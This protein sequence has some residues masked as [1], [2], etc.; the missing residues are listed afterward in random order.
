MVFN[1]TA[2]HFEES[3]RTTAG[4]QRL[5]S[6]NRREGSL[7]GRGWTAELKG[8]QQWGRRASRSGTHAEVEGI[9]FGS[10]LCST[11]STILKE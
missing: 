2:Q 4:T 3:S 5:A 10:L 11:P 6:V 9:G 1:L 8:H 7:S